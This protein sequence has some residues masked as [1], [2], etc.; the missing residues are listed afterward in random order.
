[1][2]PQ[3]PAEK[4]EKAEGNSEA[5][6]D[7]EQDLTKQLA[8]A[9]QKADDYL[10]GWKRSQ[11]DFVNYKRRAEQERLEMGVYA[12]TQLIL[13]L[14]PV[15]DDFERAFDAVSHKHVKTDWVEG[16]KLVERKF[17]TILETQGLSQIKA[18]GEVFDPNLHDAVMQTKGEDGVVVKE[19]EKGYKLQ[20]KIIRHSKVA[21]GNGEPLEESKKTNKEPEK[22]ET[23][24]EEKKDK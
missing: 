17:K 18:T 11:A 13:A 16:V 15:L 7:S 21:V 6:A 12:N 2:I 9:K 8:Y 1:M 3:E 14:L 5:T 10:D 20:D 22:T 23:T 19:F 4:P 24:N